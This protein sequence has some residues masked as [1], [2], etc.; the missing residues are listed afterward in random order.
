MM[1]LNTI[2]ADSINYISDQ[3]EALLKTGLKKEIAIQN[4]VTDVL[5]VTSAFYN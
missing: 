3:I 5:K 2:V 4:V 1:L